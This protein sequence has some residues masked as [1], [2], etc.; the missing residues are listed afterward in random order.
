MPYWLDQAFCWNSKH[1]MQLPN[2]WQGQR[3]FS[4]Q[5]FINTILAANGGNKISR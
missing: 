2:H 3:S 4:I 5:H 1:L